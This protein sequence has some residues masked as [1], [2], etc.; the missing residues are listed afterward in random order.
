MFLD[1]IPKQTQEINTIQT[2]NHETHH[3]TEIETIQII[4]TEVIRTIEI[5][6]TRTINQEITHIRDQT[7]TDQ[8]KIIKIDHDTIH[9]F[10]L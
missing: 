7:T 3:I 6:L 2:I 4:E 10:K 8:T 9:K 1:P 5:K